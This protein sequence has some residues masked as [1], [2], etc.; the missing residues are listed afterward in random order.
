MRMLDAIP[1]LPVQDMP[2]SVT[3]YRDNLGWTVVHQETSFAIVQRDEVAIHLWAA[4]DETWRTRT[5]GPPVVS[6][7]ESF[8]AG[9]ASCRVYLDDIDGLYR[10]LDPLGI[11]HPNGRL[12]ATP[13]G[14]REFGILDPDGN[15]ITFAERVPAPELA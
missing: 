3:F 10:T 7:A 9:T 2:R 6:G 1:A 15:L 11:V 13:W 5:S 4:A 14:T 12:R 8:I